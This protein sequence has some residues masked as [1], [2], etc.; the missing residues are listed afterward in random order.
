MKPGDFENIS[1]S[2]ILHFVQGAV[3][4]NE[5]A[6]QLHKKVN[7]SRSAWVTRCPSLRC[8]SV[9]L[10]RNQSHDLAKYSFESETLFLLEHFPDH[11]MHFFF[12]RK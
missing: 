1:V 7:H 5:W 4:P 10:Y 9:L 2:K 6:T 12:P 11:M 3:L 8:Y